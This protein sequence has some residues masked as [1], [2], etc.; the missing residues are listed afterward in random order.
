M[1][2]HN[3]SYIRPATWLLMA[4]VYSG[5]TTVD[6][7]PDFQRA[8]D[9][10]NEHTGVDDVYDPT[11][12]DLIDGKVDDLLA[13]GLTVDEAVRVALLNNRSFQALF[14][15]IGASRADVVQ[16]GLLS[17]PSVSFLTQFPE[18]GGRAK[19][20]VGFAQELV[21]LWQIPVRK[22]IAQEQLQQTVL[23][24]TQRAVALAADAK[25]A[26][27]RLLVARQAEGTGK[28]GV[29][30]FRQSLDLADR[31]FKAGE[32]S[33]VDVDLARS[34]LT[35]A[36]LALLS[37]QRDRRLA[38]AALAR[39]LGLNR[40]A[41]SWELVGPLPDPSA[42]PD[43]ET[44][45]RM[46][47]TQRIDGRLARSQVDAAEQELRLEVLH[48]FPSLEVG[49][50]LERT[51][52]RALPGR[53]ILADT[54]RAS[55]RNGRLTAPDIQTRAERNL[56]RRQIIDSLLGPTITFAL[57]IWD[58]NQAQIAKARFK[59]HQ[60]RKEFEDLLDAVAYEVQRAST[61]ARN[62]AAQVRY[63]E[64]EVLPLAQKN[65]DAARRL[66]QAGEQGIL[67]LIESQELFIEQRRFYED[68]VRDRAVAI[69]EL[70]AAVGGR[71]DWPMDEPVGPPSTMLE[72]TSK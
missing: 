18:G 67:V 41:T 3:A 48:V 29:E 21:D 26:C 53:K 33:Q 64:R 1:V 31:Q 17:N 49:A 19:L 71:L 2:L 59:V 50:T 47:M 12:E 45:L 22:R 10:I 52:R 23:E 62:A 68:A 39:V 61:I 5:C 51:D 44:L 6:P 25:S 34:E 43:D 66:Y 7:Q 24:V 4:T 58:Q 69:A 38:E 54:A 13:D 20:E 37:L 40:M 30:L 32:S 70:E 55:V 9:L 60:K 36:E 35:Q 11:T 56:E 65:V 14:Q 8:T 46:A 28:K 27:Y 42:L 72:P 15:T 57:P 16:S 63:Y